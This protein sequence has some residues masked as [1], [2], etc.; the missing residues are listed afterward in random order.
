MSV[1]D[2]R[3]P[4]KPSRLGLY[5]PFVLLLI[6][7]LA[8]TV[9]WF[10]ARNQTQ[11]RM[12]A[13][14]ADLKQAG[15]AVTWSQRTLG[16]YPFRMDVTLTDVSARDPSGWALQ[17]PRLEGEA[18]MYALGHWLVAA[19]QGLTFVRPVGG[20][21]AVKGDLI[22]ASLSH[23]DKRPPS[24]SFEGVK[25]SFAPGPGAQPFALATA[26]RVEFHL[27]A[28]PDDEGGVFAE[29]KNGRAVAA[30]LLG[31]IAGDRPVS[32]AWNSTLSKMSAFEGATWPEAVRN[33]AAAGGRMNVRNAG[34][35]AGEAALGATSG[36]LGVGSDGR[37][38]GALDVTLR[39]APRALAI[40]GET[41]A[42]PQPNAAAALVVA[43]ARQGAGQEA[44]AVLTFQAGRTTLG[45]VSVGP[46]PKV[47]D[48]R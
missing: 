20:P 35:T 45:P 28:G 40:M 23:L 10:W 14:V 43:Q 33:W 32:M 13:A 27:R 24:F 44:R 8:W 34:V 30:T 3:P 25:L 37:L 42:I 47:Y 39:Q 4:R 22:R 6:A 5:I 31:R 18:F 29:V 12:D 46:A 15:Y 48:V 21:V 38:N 9:V 19:P 36:S 7:I 11:V 2:R 16:G 41:G 17:A 1:H 26:D